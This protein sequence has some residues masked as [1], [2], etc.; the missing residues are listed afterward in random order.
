[1]YALLIL[2]LISPFGGYPAPPA[3][4]GSTGVY[5][6]T[7]HTVIVKLDTELGE[8]VCDATIY[9]YHEEENLLLGTGITNETGYATFTWDIPTTHKLGPTLLNATFKGDPDRFL[10]PCY[11]PI[12]LTVY[13]Y[14]NLT[15]DVFDAEGSPV[16]VVYQ[17]QELTFRILVRDDN[18]EP[19]AGVTVLFLDDESRLIAQDITGVDGTTTFTYRLTEISGSILRFGIK[20]LNLDYYN[21]SMINLY[22]PVGKSAT[23][24]LDLPAFLRRGE[25]HLSG[26]LHH[27]YRRGIGGARIRL[28]LDS[29]FEVA[30]TV[31]GEGGVFCFNISSEVYMTGRFLTVIYDGSKVHKP[32]RAIVGLIPSDTLVPFAQ[33][34]R[35]IPFG[36]EIIF[37]T[38]IMALSCLTAI[39]ILGIWKSRRT[40]RDIIAH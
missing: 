38:E 29:A 26:K 10:L 28:L 17:D 2:L 8:P 1:M 33:L 4:G 24:L 13:A 31:T 36:E 7:A 19:L 37:Q 9:F 11:V 39:S 16:K 25:E 21:G 12:P 15:V 30:E 5:R 22:F 40:T 20:T 14:T 32:V 6:G 23:M 18:L 34:I 35:P 3:I 27:Q